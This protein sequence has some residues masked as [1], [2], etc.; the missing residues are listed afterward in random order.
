MCCSVS[1]RDPEQEKGQHAKMT[2]TEHC[3]DDIISSLV[4]VAGFS[5]GDDVL[6]STPLVGR[7]PDRFISR[8]VWCRGYTEVGPYLEHARNGV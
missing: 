7:A 3:T 6:P 4:V 1:G 8:V 2:V 5:L